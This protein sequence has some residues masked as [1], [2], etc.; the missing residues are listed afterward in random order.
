MDNNKSHTAFDV[1]K[2]AYA[3]LLEENQLLKNEIKRLQNVENNT[4]L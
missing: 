3:M 4:E 2:K 1:L